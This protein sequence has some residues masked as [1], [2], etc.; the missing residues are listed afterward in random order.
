VT[1]P[2]VVDSSVGPRPPVAGITDAGR[3]WTA[4][5]ISELSIPCR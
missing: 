5:M 4:W 1:D 3:E 2:L